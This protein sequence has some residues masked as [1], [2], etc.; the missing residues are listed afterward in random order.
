M[1]RLRKGKQGKMYWWPSLLNS[2]T[3]GSLYKVVVS[4][5]SDALKSGNQQEFFDYVT[6]S[7]DF[8]IVK[9]WSKLIC[10]SLFSMICFLVL[11]MIEKI[12]HTQKSKQSLRKPMQWRLLNGADVF[13]TPCVREFY[14]D[15]DSSSRTIEFC[16][17]TSSKQFRSTKNAYPD[18]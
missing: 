4:Y 9:L 11:K 6:M 15:T 3:V 13:W 7:F 16:E 17:F 10:Y 2:I 12:L 14:Q 5:Y 8:D 1:V 18:L